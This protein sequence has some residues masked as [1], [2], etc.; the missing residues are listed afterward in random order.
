MFASAEAFH[1]LVIRD[2]YA[3]FLSGLQEKVGS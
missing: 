1:G 2:A 3:R